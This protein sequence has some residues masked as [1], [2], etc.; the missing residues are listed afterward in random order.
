VNDDYAHH[1]S[2]VRATLAAARSRFGERRLVA[3]LQ[4]HTYS[5]THALLDDWATAFGDPASNP[6]EGADVVRVG[7]IYAARERDTLG[8]DS[9]ALARRMEHPDA[10]AVGGM[11]HAISALIELLRPGDVLLTLGAGDSHKVGEKILEKLGV[12]S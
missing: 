10:R 9:A 8:V 4:P 2:E 11:E 12:E 5:R 6:G 3:Y 7:D 1:P